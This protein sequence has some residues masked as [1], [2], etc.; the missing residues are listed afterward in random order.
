MA[1]Y[2]IINEKVANLQEVFDN[3]KNGGLKLL[4]FNKNTRRWSQVAWCG[5]NQIEVIT[6]END[7]IFA[8]YF[9]EFPFN[10][11]NELKE[12]RIFITDKIWYIGHIED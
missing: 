8:E 1:K 10:N 6:I 12:N 2:S 7:K 4:C 11:L 5:E 9:M 3:L